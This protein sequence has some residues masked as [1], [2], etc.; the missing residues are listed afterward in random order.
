M[1]NVES[2]TQHPRFFSSRPQRFKICFATGAQQFS[3]CVY[4]DGVILSVAGIQA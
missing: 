4:H 3:F 2:K 1:K